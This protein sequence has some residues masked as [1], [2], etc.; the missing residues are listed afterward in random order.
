MKKTIAL[1][2]GGESAEH[3]ISLIS[4]KN[5]YLGANQDRFKIIPIG[6]SKTGEWYL[7]TNISLFKSLD[8][9]DGFDISKH[10]DPISL[11]R[12]GSQIFVMRLE[13]Q[14]VVTALDGAFP[15]V[16]GHKGE[17]GNLQGFLETLGL[18]YVGADTLSSAIAMDKDVMKRLLSTTDGI[19]VPS[20]HVIQ[21]GEETSYKEISQK[22]GETLF[23][24]PCNS[25][26][27]I[28]I[29][30]VSNE[31]EFSKACTE[32]FRYD[33]KVILES[34]VK[35]REMEISILGTAKPRISLPGEI[36]VSGT[37]YDYESKYLKNTDLSIPAKV[38]EEEKTELQNA[39]LKAYKSLCIKGMAR[40]DLFLKSNGEVLVNEINTLPGFTPIS[41]YP[42]LWVISGLSY[43]DLITELI[44]ESL[45]RN[46]NFK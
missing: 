39:A 21:K 41:M 26:S 30:C 35:G 34:F 15:I 33:S 3:N 43:K 12:K 8:T 6:I 42:K 24:K 2:M 22:L 27:S 37:Y 7:I 20:F 1:I 16:H 14:G 32:A 45:N 4:A 25:G 29:N 44:D 9:Y 38:T 36:V 28:G 46:S 19:R 31:E 13:T 18:P 11:I 10:G 23:I 40:V 5:I 17:D